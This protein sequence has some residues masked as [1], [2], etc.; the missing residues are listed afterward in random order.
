[1]RS[2]VIAASN[3]RFASLR[4]TEAM[5]DRG[6]WQTDD[7][8]ERD[9]LV[10][11]E[12]PLNA[13]TKLD[14]QRGPAV[15]AGRHYV[16]T[17][18]GIPAEP[19]EVVLTG[20]IRESRTLTL[21]A[22]RMLPSRTLEVTL[23]CAGN[24]RK[25]LEPR[26]SGEQWGLGAVG[27]AKWTGAALH[28]VLERA[29]LP[30]AV[31]VL[32]RGADE[33][34]PGDLGR[35]IA[36]ERSL[37]VDIAAGDDVLVAYAMNGQPI[38]REHGGPLRLIVPSWYGMASVKW[39]AEIRLLDRPFDGFFQKDR[40]VIEGSPL[41]GI[42]PRAVITSPADGADVSAGPLEVR[43]YAWSGRAPVERVDLSE[44]DG[45]TLGSTTFLAVTPAFAWREFAFAISL[46]TGDHV[47]VSR[48]T[49]RDGNTQPVSPR[50]NALG[51]ANNA[52]RPTRVRVRS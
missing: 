10:L 34:V 33:G 48:A 3:A 46:D 24:G 37:P 51:Y 36:Y 43:G 15:A 20:A 14:K 22:V 26:V 30:S 45:T 50:W 42:E 40:Y 38:P 28:A 47:L 4:G 23:E 25:F 21:H 1:M 18:F 19:R 32:F 11:S 27:N 13:E 17:H 8:P 39:L 2:V 12:E 5:L 9:L 16:R 29:W 31:E 49:D 35:R 52:V 6:R 7:V 44:S 41:R